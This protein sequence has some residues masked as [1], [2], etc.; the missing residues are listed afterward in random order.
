MANIDPGA[1]TTANHQHV[2]VR[3]GTF[4]LRGVYC[5]RCADAV[6]R[7]LRE[8]PHVTEVRL[9]WKNNV[10][11]VGYD[12]VRNGA[13]AVEEVI[14]QTG[15]DCKL[16]EVEE[17][18]HEAMAPPVRRMQ[19]LEHGVDAQPIAMGTKHDRM[20]YEAP[21]TQADHSDHMGDHMG[22]DMSDPGMAEAMER[23]MRNR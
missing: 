6:E 7:A 4:E 11:H 17:E 13:E 12:P 10:V 5:L 14:T 20:Q 16:T 23:D 18:H 21:A 19:H 1:A 9:D 15:C 2:P 22:H 8:Q 3:R